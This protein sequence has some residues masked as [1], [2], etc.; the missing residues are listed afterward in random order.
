MEGLWIA[1]AHGHENVIE[2]LLQILLDNKQLLV[3]SNV[4]NDTRES[5]SDGPRLLSTDL[6]FKSDESAE[7]DSSASA[8]IPPVDEPKRLL[9]TGTLWRGGIRNAC[10]NI[11]PHEKWSHLVS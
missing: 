10:I 5:D 8:S 1:I 2:V 7:Q 9:L 11:I 6:I 3:P 4:L